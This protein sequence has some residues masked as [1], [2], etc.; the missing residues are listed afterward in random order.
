MTKA[1]IKNR[2]AFFTIFSEKFAVTPNLA[3]HYRSSNDVVTGIGTW[4]IPP[5]A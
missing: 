1:F 2:M 3:G 5:L 4:M